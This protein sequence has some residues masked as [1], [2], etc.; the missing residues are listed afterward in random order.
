MNSPMPTTTIAV[1]QLATVAATSYRMPTPGTVKPIMAMKCIDPDAGAADR[2][3]GQQEPAGPSL[4]VHHRP[5]PDRTD[6]PEQRPEHGKRV[7]ERRGHD[8]EREM[9]DVHV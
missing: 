6:Q 8:P 7:G 1:I 4:V 2:P 9:V 5:S 3:G